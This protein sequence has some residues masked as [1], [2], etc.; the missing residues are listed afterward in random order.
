[1]IQRRTVVAG[2]AAVTLMPCP[3]GAQQ[4]DKVYRVGVLSLYPPST[5]PELMRAF[6]QGMREV[7]YVEGRHYVLEMQNA[8][9]KPDRLDSVARTL[10]AQGVDVILIGAGITLAAATAA[11]NT[12]PIVI[13]TVT[14]DP[15]RR[16]HAASLARPAG[17][18]TGLSGVQMEGVSGK[19]LEFLRELVPGLSRIFVVM[20]P[21][22]QSSLADE[23]ES[24]AKGFGLAFARIRVTNA[25]DIDIALR[26]L[27]VRRGDGIVLF[28]EAPLWSRRAR[29]ADLVAKKKLPAI[30]TLKAYVEAGGLMSYAPSFEDAFRRSATYVDK[31]LRGAKPG[32]LPIERPTKFELVINLR[33]ARALGLTIPPSLLLRAD[34][35]I[36]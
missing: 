35:L 32:D 1:M 26:N 23:V 36:E 11:T 4:A 34:Q 31:I 18:V 6:R 16:G 3:I 21:T 29:I 30:Y 19:W 33:T 8:D 9:G 28:S 20:N 10:V 22:S 25:D 27:A 12:I 24:A 2:I 13:A 14:S 7:G 5:F 15:V 17:N